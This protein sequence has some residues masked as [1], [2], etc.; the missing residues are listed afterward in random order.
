MTI[1]YHVVI[2]YLGLSQL[3]LR[4]C[5]FASL[6]FWG[7]L[8]DQIIRPCRPCSSG[9]FKSDKGN[10][11][12]SSCPT[13][14]RG[15]NNGTSCGATSIFNS[16]TDTTTIVSTQSTQTMTTTI[17][18]TQSTQTGTTTIVSTQSTQN[19]TTTTTSALSTPQLPQSIAPP[20][21]LESGTDF[22][23]IVATSTAGVVV[24]VIS[25]LLVWQVR[26]GRTQGIAKSTLATPTIDPF[27]TTLHQPGQMPFSGTLMPFSQFP[28]QLSQ[29][30]FMQ[31]PT[32]LPQFPTQPFQQR[33]MNRPTQFSLISP[34]SNTTNTFNQTSYSPGT[35]R[36]PT[37]PNS[38]LDNNATQTLAATTPTMQ[39]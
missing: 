37:M 18:S 30:A 31:H 10:S 36:R 38:M 28:T 11:I 32:H 26:K 6:N 23:L 39:F 8:T 14:S 33:S 20:E 15:V 1:L 16:H 4:T 35:G 9:T 12:C 21:K 25:M 27:R 17:I 19:G 29:Q 22:V 24:L 13:A 2:V 34:Y 5:M 7:I 3:V